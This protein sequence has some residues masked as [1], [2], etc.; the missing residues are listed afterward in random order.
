MRTA[1]IVVFG[2]G[3]SMR[4]AVSTMVQSTIG[5]GILTMPSALSDCGII[6]GMVFL[7]ISCVLNFMAGW[8]IAR[9]SLNT[10]IHSF[11]HIAATVADGKVWSFIVDMMTIL[12][13][14]GIMSGGLFVFADS[15]EDILQDVEVCI[16][17]YQLLLFLTG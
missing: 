5:A 6:L 14:L 10:N 7:L 2:K 3:G 15:M 4:S 17:S 8:A 11:S 9:A 13:V 12:L 16:L 1:S